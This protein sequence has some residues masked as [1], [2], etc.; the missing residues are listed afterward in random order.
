MKQQVCAVFYFAKS[1]V[2]NAFTLVFIQ[3]ICVACLLVC[4]YTNQK[5]VDLC[6]NSDWSLI[7]ILAKNIAFWLVDLMQPFFRAWRD[8]TASQRWLIF[9]KQQFCWDDLK[10]R[11]WYATMNPWIQLWAQGEMCGNN[12]IKLEWHIYNV[13]FSL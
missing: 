12:T 4:K 9:L 8:F 2:N 11:F 7:Y 3:F 6:T 10:A 1:H 5:K 13:S